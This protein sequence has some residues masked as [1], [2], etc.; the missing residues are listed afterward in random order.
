MRR[1]R[2]TCSD[3][4][5]YGQATTGAAGRL[6][7]ARLRAAAGQLAGRDYARGEPSTSAAEVW[8][9]GTPA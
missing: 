9:S 6:E 3:R 2:A 5:V 7:L 1:L 4:E 8:S